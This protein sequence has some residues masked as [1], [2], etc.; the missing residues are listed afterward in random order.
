[1][2]GSRRSAAGVQRADRTRQR[3]P[4]GK[5]HVQITVEIEELGHG[6]TDSP[7]VADYV[8]ALFKVRGLKAAVAE[9]V[10]EAEQRRN[11]LNGAQL[12]E[13][14]RLV[15]DTGANRRHYPAG[16]G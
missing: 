2:P 5:G 14:L 1:V 9:A 11:R 15:Y 4:G 8:H 12:N 3:Q 7:A 6:A 10:A 16:L 13:A